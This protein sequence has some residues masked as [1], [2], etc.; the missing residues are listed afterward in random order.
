MRTEPLLRARYGGK[1]HSNVLE[2]DKPGG[3]SSLCHPYTPGSV[4]GGLRPA[5]APLLLG[6]VPPTLVTSHRH[7][8]S[9]RQPLHSTGPETESPSSWTPRGARL[10]S[11]DWADHLSALPTAEAG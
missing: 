9:G 11:P 2:T 8:N 6:T 3:G 5:P 7:G 1:I 10:Q 4:V